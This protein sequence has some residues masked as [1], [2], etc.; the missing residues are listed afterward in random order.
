MCSYG[1]TAF[2]I[3]KFFCVEI[4]QAELK[5]S[6]KFENFV[7]YNTNQKSYKNR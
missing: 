1:Y 6:N 5:M 3:K 7:H 2:F 4:E